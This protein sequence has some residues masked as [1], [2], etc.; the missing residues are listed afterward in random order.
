[1]HLFRTYRL[2]GAA[3]RPAGRVLLRV[4]GLEDRAVPAAALA[5][6]FHATVIAGSPRSSPGDSTDARIDPNTTSSPYAGVGSLQIVARN[7]SFIATATVIGPRHVL[8]AAHVVDLNND[9]KVDRKD[10]TQGVYFILNVGGD[11][12]AKIPVT[13]FDLAPDFTGF[14]RPAV[15][16]DLAVLTLAQDVP[17]DIPIYQLP[18][19]ELKEGTVL[20]FVG[21]G[22]PGD[23]VRGYTGPADPSVKRV[24]ENTVDAFFGQDDK[25]RPEGNEVFRFDFDGPAGNGRLGG[26]TLG[27][28]RE[29]QLGG[30]DSGGP[31]FALMGGGLVLAGVASFTQGANAPRFGSMGG[32]VNLYPYLSFITS[33]LQPPETPPSTTPPPGGNYPRPPGS[34]PVSPLRNPLKNFPP[35][36]PP[37]AP[38]PPPPGSRPEPPP[39]PDDPPVAEPLPPAPIP[40]VP[41]PPIPPVSPPTDELPP[42]GPIDPSPEPDPT[43]P[44]RPDDDTSKDGEYTILPSVMPALTGSR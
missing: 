32:G 17:S 33:V 12:T 37:P 42:P 36:P 22:R 25:N 13:G 11:Q 44:L 19:E 28:D 21:Y 14:N 2:P 3:G 35:P 31:A 23:G 16:D 30:G 27:N 1:M 6:E 43:D 41:P 26:P 20:T 29:T 15:N 39:I 7:K 24:G 9:G 34:R 38:Q 10:G 8:T 18:T 4:E 40:P 5:D